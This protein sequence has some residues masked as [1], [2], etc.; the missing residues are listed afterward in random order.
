MMDRNFHGVFSLVLVYAAVI[1]ALIYLL[2]LSAAL[3]SVY[4]AIVVISNPIVLYAYCAKCVCRKEACGHVFPG[5]LTRLLPERKQGP[6]T[7]GDYFWTC[8]SLMALLGFPQVWLWQ[9]RILF[10]SYWILLLVGLAEIL[11]LVCRACGNEN[12][13]VRRS[14]FG[15]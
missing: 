12:C 11:F 6:Y 5:K 10:V 15:A 14:A 4:L 1:I 7:F 8:V 13:P 9:N 3:G 2:D